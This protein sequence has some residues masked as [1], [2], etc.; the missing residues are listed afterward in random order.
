METLGG[1]TLF[2]DRRIYINPGLTEAR[3]V[4]VL[5]HEVLHATYP[6]LEESA[7]QRGEANIADALCSAGITFAVT[8]PANNPRHPRVACWKDDVDE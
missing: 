4:E 5:I 2:D 1:L 8:E 3:A 7:V 6:D